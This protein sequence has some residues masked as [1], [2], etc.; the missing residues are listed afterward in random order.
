MRRFSFPLVAAASAALAAAVGWGVGAWRRQP[1]PSSI[2]VVDN[3][4]VV[5]QVFCASCHGPEGH[6]DGS[7]AA[8]LRPPPRDFAA[9]PWRFGPS[10]DAIRR[11][12]LDGIPGTGMASFRAALSPADLVPRPD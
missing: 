8:T 11:V 3:G 2:P 12:I 7:S 6:G 1:P 4:P 10:P 9:R 5:Y